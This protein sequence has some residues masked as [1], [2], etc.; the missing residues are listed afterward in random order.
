MYFNFNITGK[1]WDTNIIPNKIFIIDFISDAGRTLKLTNPEMVKL[2][3]K[4]W[5]RIS[6]HTHKLLYGFYKLT[7]QGYDNLDQRPKQRAFA[8]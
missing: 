4:H 8:K 1:N 2:H 6:V 5:K 3:D 7:R